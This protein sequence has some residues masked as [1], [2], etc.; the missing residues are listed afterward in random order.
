M[1]IHIY[2]Y[3][4]TGIKYLYIYIYTHIYLS[5]SLSLFY[6]VLSCSLSLSLPL[7]LYIFSIRSIGS[8]LHQCSGGKRNH[9]SPT[10]RPH[11]T[12]STLAAF[13]LASE[14]TLASPY[15]SPPPMQKSRSISELRATR[16][17]LA[18]FRNRNLPGSCDLARFHPILVG[19]LEHDSYFSIYVGNIHPN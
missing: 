8:I 17:A 6:N 4:H 13:A 16:L 2:I 15:G 9:Q 5:L 14:S 19:G 7:P 12:G 11:D 10:A 3:I 18:A 1:I